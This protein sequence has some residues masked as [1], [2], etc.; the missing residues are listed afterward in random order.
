MAALTPVASA[1]ARYASAKS[2]RAVVQ[3]EGAQQKLIYDGDRGSAIAARISSATRARLA[4][5]G[6]SHR[7]TSAERVEQ[8]ERIK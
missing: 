3:L 7:G 6:E 8:I 4:I 2:R 1:L 5:L